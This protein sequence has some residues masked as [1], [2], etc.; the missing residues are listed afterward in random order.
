[1]SQIT[2]KVADSNRLELVPQFKLD[3]P[4]IYQIGIALK[5]NLETEHICNRL[6]AESM[7]IALSAHLLRYYSTQNPKI[8]SYS[9]GL[10][11]ARLQQVTDYIHQHSAQN[12]SLMVMA[13]IVQMSPY[14]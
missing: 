7:A 3:D 6:Y 13:E 2:A 8:K 1:M 10:S 12:I 4:L 14:Y 9:D 5:A 11:Q